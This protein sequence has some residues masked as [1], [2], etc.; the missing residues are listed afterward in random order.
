[1]EYKVIE[2]FKDR[3]NRMYYVGD[4]YPAPGYTVSETRIKQV[5]GENRYK[6]PFVVA[7]EE[8]RRKRTKAE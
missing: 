6:R 7:V 3:D 1:M 4:V 2:S 5:L 8:P